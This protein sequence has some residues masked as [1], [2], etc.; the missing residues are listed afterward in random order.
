MRKTKGKGRFR[1]G[2][3]LAL[4]VVFGCTSL[5][6]TSA[7][8]DEAY[9][10]NPPVIE[11]VEMVPSADPLTTNDSV[12]IR[13]KAYDAQSGISSIYANVSYAD[14]NGTVST[15]SQGVGLTSTGAENTYEGTVQLLNYRNA[16]TLCLSSLSVKDM[17]NNEADS[18][19]FISNE[20]SYGSLD[21]YKTKISFSKGDMGTT[22]IKASSVGLYKDSL[23]TE[24]IEGQTLVGDNTWFYANMV[25]TD[26]TGVDSFYARFDGEAGTV[27]NDIKFYKVSDN[28]SGTG[29][30]SSY[31]LK[32]L[33]E[34]TFHLTHIF[35][36]MTDGS[37][38]DVTP[39]DGTDYTSKWF[40][41]QKD[42]S[43]APSDETPAYESINFKVNGQDVSEEQ[44]IYPG[45]VVDV[46]VTIQADKAYED[47]INSM[48][49]VALDDNSSREW[50][51][52]TRTSADSNVYTG[53]FKVTENTYP[54]VW[55]LRGMKWASQS[56]LY[57][58]IS[59]YYFTV[60]H[61]EGGTVVLPTYN[62]QFYV[63]YLEESDGGIVRN[64]YN[65]DL[66]DL[67]MFSK[68]TADQLKLGDAPVSVGGANIL[69]WHVYKNV[70]D[71]T[72]SVEKDCGALEDYKITSNQYSVRVSPVYDK[73]LVTV[74][75][76]YV[77]DGEFCTDD[78]EYTYAQDEAITDEIV[79][80][81]LT[82]AGQAEAGVA[83][84][85]WVTS[86]TADQIN[87]QLTY[88]HADVYV[89]ACY[90]GKQI[91]V[92]QYDRGTMESDTY[93]EAVLVDK[94]MT[95]E[96]LA[97][98]FKTPKNNP[99]EGIDL[100]GA[101]KV[102]SWEYEWAEP[103]DYLAYVRYAAD[104]ENCIVQFHVEAS[105]NKVGNYYMGFVEGAAFNLPNAMGNFKDIKW[106][107]KGSWTGSGKD[108][109]EEIDGTGS[110]TAVK[111][112]CFYGTGTY[113]NNNSGTSNGSTDSNTST[114]NN[115]NA[116]GSTGN[117]AGTASTAYTPVTMSTE[118]IASEV[119]T[120]TAA[121]NA[122]QKNVT[123]SM[124]GA[125]VVP[126]AILETAKGK[127]INI[128]LDMGG[129]SWTIN[130]KDIKADNLK[131]IDLKVNF[132]TKAVPD[133]LVSALAGSN[134]TK[135]ISLAYNG[136]FGFK[137]NLSFNIG[138]ENKGKY[139]NLYYYDSNGKLV[140]MNAGKIAD[141]GTVSLEF[142]HASDYVIVISEASMAP[143]APKT[144]DDSNIFGMIALLFGGTAL[145]LAVSKKR[146]LKI[147]R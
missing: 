114:G 46:T 43:E 127:D 73:K 111:M 143:K 23:C 62:A 123:I 66:K 116:S 16:G 140:F 88:G 80:S 101:V 14:E 55:E 129:Y 12:I 134:P 69:S 100:N 21:Y 51:D 59:G 3:A 117:T 104:Y 4:A 91:V 38:V 144:G 96:Q 82:R 74:H 147:Y 37:V 26:D 146:K 107:E 77:K 99:F 64:S 11:S 89:T 63:S 47:T 109:Y 135:Q 56:S 35:A 86:N 131:D 90:T 136:D 33:S 83:F 118:K 106:K 87:S 29:Y 61:G 75:Y 128:I 137:A 133:S 71:G 124:D 31:N 121:V 115:V 53:Q 19:T 132:D 145:L 102:K 8:A 24:S 52:L 122:G 42:G 28:Y 93:E 54:S 130:G 22:D 60:Q 67:T 94:G 6:T 50:V 20:G 57:W 125:T 17:N 108:T 78:V 18:S 65:V 44:M 1:R 39:A 105:N 119:N 85:K 92:A 70:W 13:V 126:T 5:D 48:F 45:S 98:Q 120:I 41:F 30:V 79:N 81:Y 9:D 103:D 10:V 95:E 72:K 110:F 138:N 49:K 141:D 7:L 139:G 97:E 112:M 25:V 76:D 84:E 113:E 36:K 2:I 27:I 68:V 40:K 34:E 142:S 15:S 32:G 58:N